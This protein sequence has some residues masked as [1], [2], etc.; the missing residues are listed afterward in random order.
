MGHNMSEFEEAYRLFWEQPDKH[1][2]VK[3]NNPPMNTHTVLILEPRLSILISE[4]EEELTKLGKKMIEHGV[5]VFDNFK[6]F[7]EWHDNRN[8]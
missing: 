8:Q 5:K 2:L 3:L 6:E 1:A 4:D 7:Y